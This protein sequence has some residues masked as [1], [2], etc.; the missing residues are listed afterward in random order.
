MVPTPASGATTTKYGTLLNNSTYNSEFTIHDIR[1][2]GGLHTVS[3][4]NRGMNTFAAVSTVLVIALVTVGL[5]DHRTPTN[6]TTKPIKLKLK[7]GTP[8]SNPNLNKTLIIQTWTVEEW[9][10]NMFSPPTHVTG[11]HLHNANNLEYLA[12]LQIGTPPVEYQLIVDTGSSNTWVSGKECKDMGCS[13]M[14]AFDSHASSTFLPSMNDFHLKYGTG[15]CSGKI[16]YD[17]IG[18]E[19]SSVRIRLALGIATSVDKFFEGVPFADG[20][21][22]LGLRRLSEGRQTTFVQALFDSREI[23]KKIISVSLREDASELSFGAVDHDVFKPPL[24]YTP[25]Q[26]LRG[27]Y[28][29]YIIELQGIFVDGKKIPIDTTRAI[30][31]TGTS[32]ILGPSKDVRSIVSALGPTSV[33]VCSEKT[34]QVGIGGSLFSIPADV[35]NLDSDCTLGVQEDSL[36]PNVFIFGDT[37]FRSVYTVFDLDSMQLG[38]APHKNMPSV[39]PVPY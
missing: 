33:G 21:L 16:G 15:S 22:G 5:T 20:I 31:D 3:P 26:K 13:R 9:I 8:W 32:V 2:K 29:Y 28:L 10:E 37:F 24:T 36:M 27:T 4:W 35:Y 34:I 38:V 23:S 14:K 18:L 6:P 30:I 19:G 12:Y 11:R 39:V 7:R 25:F 1:N 17:Q